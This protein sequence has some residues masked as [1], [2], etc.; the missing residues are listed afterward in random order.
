MAVYLLREF[1][2]KDVINGK[3]TYELF[4][5]SPSSPVRE[6][7]LKRREETIF[8]YPI[9]KVVECGGD[10]RRRLRG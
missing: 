5:G 1:R 4:L 10:R 9:V 7:S 3:T 2:E 8:N 6:G